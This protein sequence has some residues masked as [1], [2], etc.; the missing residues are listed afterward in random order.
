MKNFNRIV[1]ALL[2]VALAAA[3]AATAHAAPKNPKDQHN[4]RPQQIATVLDA[5]DAE[6]FKVVIYFRGLDLP[7]VFPGSANGT[8]SGR[9]TQSNG[10]A[11]GGKLITFTVDDG[12]TCTAVT[13]DYG[14]ASCQVDVSET[15]DITD[16][17]ISAVFGGDDTHL[18]SSD[19]AVMTKVP[20]VCTYNYS[21]NPFAC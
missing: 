6:E 9:L 3:P 19:Q 10:T 20:V 4:S 12:R 8:L 16:H 13:N 5:Y 7:W 11:V 21:L 17:T 15:T 14:Q 18:A 2:A 1:G